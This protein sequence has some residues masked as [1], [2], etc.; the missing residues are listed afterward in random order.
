MVVRF[1]VRRMRSRTILLLIALLGGGLLNTALVHGQQDPEREGLRQF[2]QQTINGADS[3]E[4]RFDAEV[5]LVDMQHRLS[6]FIEAD[7]ER[8]ELLRQIHSAATRSE[9]PPE[10]V[11]ALIEVESGFDRFAISRV[12]AQG[13]MQVMPFWKN[14]IGRAD[15]NLTDTRTNLNYGCRILQY[16]IQRQRGDLRRPTT[17]RWAAVDTVIR[18]TEHGQRD[19][20]PSRWTGNTGSKRVLLAGHRMV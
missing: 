17:V 6:P 13:F 20:A 10:L 11:L 18:Y 2:L 9:L 8:L 7:E 14:E 5:W 12:G 15:D 1:S 3:F 4:D 19:G 16:Y